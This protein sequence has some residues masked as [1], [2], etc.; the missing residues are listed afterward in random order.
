[1][2]RVSYFTIKI[3]CKHQLSDTFENEG[4]IGLIELIPFDTNDRENTKAQIKIGSEAFS[5]FCTDKIYTNQNPRLF[6]SCVFNPADTIELTNMY[7]VDEVR[8]YI[9]MIKK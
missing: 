5:V 2:E 8:L 6:V 1:M 3:D 7:N 9:K 4:E